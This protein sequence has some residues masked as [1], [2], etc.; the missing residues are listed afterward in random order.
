MVGDDEID[1]IVT[2]GVVDKEI[3]KVLDGK[4][5]MKEKHYKE[6]DKFP[7]L[8]NGKFVPF[9]L[10]K[11]GFLEERT[12]IYLYRLV[13]DKQDYKRKLFVFHKDLNLKLIRLMKRMFST[14]S[15]T[16]LLK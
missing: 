15:I 10:S 16:S 9:V 3:D 13:C 12:K 5:K 1:F 11:L 14:S 2:N 7:D 4:H 8:V 6:Y